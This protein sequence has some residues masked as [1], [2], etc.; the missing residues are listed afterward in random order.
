MAF[1]AIAP[2]VAVIHAIKADWEGNAIIGK[3][4]GVD[5]E[6]AVA[7]K[8]VIL[9]AEEILPKLDQADIIT[10]YIDVVLPAP[11]GALPTSCHP[12]Y[13]LDGEAMLTY[14]ERV[15]DPDSFNAYLPELLKF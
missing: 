9:T 8:K 5:E 14:V 1:P 6:L 7:S 13:Q 3:N 4:K 15:S 2:D 10:Q 11:R 12:L